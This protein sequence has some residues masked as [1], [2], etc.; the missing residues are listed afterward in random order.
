MN[1]SELLRG[2]M[3]SQDHIERMSDKIY[4]L[5]MAQQD[6]EKQVFFR[7]YV[8]YT[9]GIL[10]A[11]DLLDVNLMWAAQ[12]CYDG[13]QMRWTDAGLPDEDQLSTLFLDGLKHRQNQPYGWAGDWRKATNKTPMPQRGQSV[14]YILYDD[15]NQP[16]YVG[17]TFD[18]AARL[19]AH[20]KNGKK[21]VYWVAYPCADRAEAY[22]LE[23]RLLKGEMP[24]LNKKRGA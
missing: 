5:V 8:L 14:V 2:L 17:S 24:Y 22:R 13:W 3:A 21:F 4:T 11:E 6:A 23:D 9:D 1:D 16:C 15:L 18:L 19:K 12:H 7:L 10:D 20:R